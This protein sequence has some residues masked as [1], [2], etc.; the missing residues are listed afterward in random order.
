MNMA[1]FQK[2]SSIPKYKVHTSFN[3]AIF[4]IVLPM[5]QIQGV[6]PPEEP[7]VIKRASICR[8]SQSHRLP[9]TLRCGVLEGDIL[10][11]KILSFNN[12]TPT[13]KRPSPDQTR[14]LMVLDFG[15]GVAPGDDGGLGI[16]SGESDEVLGFGDVNGFPV[17]TGR[18]LDDG[19][20]PV[21]QR[22]GVNRRLNRPVLAGAVAGDTEHAAN[23]RH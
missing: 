21:A 18:D 20:D 16:G 23:R 14:L 22:D 7:T 2:G 9:R 10:S 5:M 19:P 8:R 3:I 13:T 15:S 4:Q 12:H 11:N 6:L 1:M 17:D